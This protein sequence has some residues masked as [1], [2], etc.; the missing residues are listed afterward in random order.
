MIRLLAMAWVVLL[1]CQTVM[2]QDGAANSKTIILVIPTAIDHAWNTHM[3]DHECKLLVKCL[4]RN[5]GVEAVLSPDLDWPKDPKVLQG[6]KSIVF[7]PSQQVTS[8]LRQNEGLRKKNFLI[9]GWDLPQS[10]GPQAP[11]KR[12]WDKII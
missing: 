5:P 3:Y 2:A 9:Q 7:I 12:N 1:G 8:S 6:V 4:N 10:I 11:M